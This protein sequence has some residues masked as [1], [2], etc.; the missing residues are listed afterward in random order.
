MNETEYQNTIRDLFGIEFDADA[1]F[2][3]DDIGYG[4]DT[5]GDVPTMSPLRPNAIWMPPSESR[6]M[7]SGTPVIRL[8]LVRWG[9]QLRNR[10]GSWFRRHQ[11]ELERSQTSN[12]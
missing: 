4:F 10:S 8:T 7:S 1:F 11:D 12:C 3:D 5:I 6:R 2:P 9:G